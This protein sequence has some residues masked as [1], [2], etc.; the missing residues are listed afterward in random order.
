PDPAPCAAP[1]PARAAHHA[2][3]QAH[4]SRP[5]A[6]VAGCGPIPRE[7]ATA[8][9]ASEPRRGT[10]R[11]RGEGWGSV[12]SLGLSSGRAHSKGLRAHDT[13]S[14][15]AG[16]KQIVQTRSL[17]RTANSLSGSYLTP[18]QKSLNDIPNVI[19]MSVS[20][21]DAAMWTNSKSIGL[22]LQRAITVDLEHRIVEPVQFPGDLTG[23]IGLTGAEIV[24][25]EAI[26]LNHIVLCQ[27]GQDRDNPEFR[28][29]HQPMASLKR[30]VVV[31][32]VHNA[33]G[34]R[35]QR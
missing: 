28:R 1:A 11:S 20:P 7:R 17:C 23:C 4:H 32:T 34:G 12:V 10:R 35:T 14:D 21:S 13:R 26:G 9:I 27:H 30:H 3:H 16:R 8:R 15:S 19:L 22:G 18:I 24:D 5:L 25:I 2:R 33:D 29:G 31:T 6:S